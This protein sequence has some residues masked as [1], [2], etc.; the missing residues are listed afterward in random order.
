MGILKNIVLANA[1][2]QKHLKGRHLKGFHAKSHAVPPKGQ[3]FRP[4]SYFS[5]RFYIQSPVLFTIHQHHWNCCAFGKHTHNL[6]H[7]QN[8]FPSVWS[9]VCRARH[10]CHFENN[11]DIPIYHT[12][13]SNELTFFIFYRT[14]APILCTS[15]SH[16]AVLWPVLFIHQSFEVI[17]IIGS[18]KFGDESRSSSK[19]NLNYYV[20]NS[21]A[22]QYRF[23]VT[24][25]GKG[26]T[27][28]KAAHLSHSVLAYVDCFLGAWVNTCGH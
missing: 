12:I 13:V 15:M 14:T 3:S 2:Y 22:H 17:L 9:A 28:A 5:P 23:F 24:P 1:C 8:P 4:S 21:E 10:C 16:T 19:G 20:Q 27:T 25:I 26:L 11:V 18:P 6:S 7:K